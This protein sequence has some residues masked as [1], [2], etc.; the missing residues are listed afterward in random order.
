M[1]PVTRVLLSLLIA[2]GL[3]AILFR[4]GGLSLEQLLDSWRALSPSVYLQALTIHLGIY[5]L[6]AVRFRVL[7]PPQHRPSLGGVLAV[8]S[9]HNL[10]A[11]VLPAKTGEGTLVLYLKNFCGV[12]AGEGLASL[13]VSRLLDLAT[14]VTFLACATLWLASEGTL[15]ESWSWPLGLVL[16]LGGGL[17]FVISGRSGVL[18]RLMTAVMRLL[19]LDSTGIGRRLEAS[20][21]RIGTAL[22]D[23][24]GG[25]RLLTSGLLSVLIWTGVFVFYFVLAR[26]FGLGQDLGAAKTIFASSWAVLANLLPIN[27]LA[28]AGTQEFGWVVGF[29]LVGVNEALALS[30]GLGA[31]IVQL[32]NVVLFGLLGHLAMAVVGEPSRTQR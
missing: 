1:R 11:Y 18:V 23:A 32:A 15:A 4:W 19:R 28:G 21:Q 13:V 8:S 9:S 7:L 10:A 14:L 20:A 12:P 22:Q 17:L 31:H 25:G 27:G 24:G 30:S 29:K 26:G 5:M 16:L 3:L 2:G 6:R